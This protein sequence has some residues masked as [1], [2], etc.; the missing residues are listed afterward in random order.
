MGPVTTGGKKRMTR[1]AP[2][3]LNSA[4]NTRYRRPAHAT[5]RQAYGSRSA[6]PFGAMAA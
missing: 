1:V 6:S 2:N 5:P 4:D 3:T